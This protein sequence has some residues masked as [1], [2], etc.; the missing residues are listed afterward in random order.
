M[1]VGLRHRPSRAVNIPI[2]FVQ[3]RFAAP[4]Y[5]LSAVHVPMG[6]LEDVPAMSAV[7]DARQCVLPA[8]N[9][10]RSGARL[11]VG[12]SDHLLLHHHVKL[13]RYDRLVAALHVVLR[14]DA[15]VLYPF[16]CQEIRSDSLLQQGIPNVLFV[17]EN[18]P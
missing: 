16:L 11:Q 7:N 14:Y 8:V 2:L 10:A 4:D 1:K 15:L 3:A 6:P 12:S 17:P 9:P 5:F 13:L 18:L